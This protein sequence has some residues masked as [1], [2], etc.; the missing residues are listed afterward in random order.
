MSLRVT[1]PGPVKDLSLRVTGDVLCTVTVDGAMRCTR[2]PI[3]SLAPAAIS[4]PARPAPPPFVQVGGLCGLAADGGGICYEQDA[5]WPTA[6]PAGTL[7]LLLGDGCGVG[8]FGI[9]L[10]WGINGG[11]RLGLGTAQDAG[12][13]NPAPPTGGH[14]LVR[15]TY[16]LSH[17]CGLDLSG[18]AWCWGTDGFGAMGPGA[19]QYFPAPVRVEFGTP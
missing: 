15:A 14:E 18:R 10:C 2:F 16:S 17:G 1:L 3:S 8:S 9:A 4:L 7:T 13:P 11:A 5:R 6:F 19:V 12:F